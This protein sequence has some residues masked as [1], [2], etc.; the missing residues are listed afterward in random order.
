M[1]KFESFSEFYPYYLQQHQHP[2]CRGL[3]VSGLILSLS[4]A[5]WFLLT[6]HPLWLLSI[7]LIG[8]SFSWVGHFGFEK[9]KPAT[10][11]YPFYSL[12]GDFR[13]VAETLIGLL[14]GQAGRHNN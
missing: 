13:M 10:L 8:Y 4:L 1:P 3:H 9:N 5:G 12:L 6:G 11:G 2:V 14:A 7:P